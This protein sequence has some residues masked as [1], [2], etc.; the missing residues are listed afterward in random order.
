MSATTTHSMQGRI[1]LVTGASRG[2]GLE[3]ARTFI[4]QGASVVITGRDAGNVAKA[5]ASLGPQAMGVAA[6]VGDAAQVAALFSKIAERFGRLDVLIN[7]AA[8][9]TPE[10]LEH[11]SD[12]LLDAQLMC[13]LRGPILCIRAA[14]P[15]MRAAGGGEIISIS[16]ESVNF[17]FPLLAVY[18]ASKAGLEVLSKGL[19][20]ELS[21][22]NIRVSILRS[23]AI[24]DS[25]FGDGWTPAQKTLAYETW[26]N[27]GHLA[28]VGKS[29]GGV[30]PS[31][32][33]NAIL[34]MVTLGASG[35]MD[36]VE[37]RSR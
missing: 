19:R 5:A 3:V 25:Q 30:Q 8:L 10:F 35:S 4:S 2:L 21:P 18:A 32:I 14:I 33:A 17:P 20:A 23:G 34:N 37:L 13:N 12:A 6:D 11:T 28:L 27:S 16:T 26:R 24:A 29:N 9:G 7:N 22:D 15:L 36:L 31:V 1:A